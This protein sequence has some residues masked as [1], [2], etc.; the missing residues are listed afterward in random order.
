[1][2]SAHLQHFLTSAFSLLPIQSCSAFS[3]YFFLFLFFRIALMGCITPAFAVGLQ[4]AVAA[5]QA[6]LGE[7]A[8]GG[9]D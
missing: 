4:T 6:A 3:P 5:V 7:C 2:R 1:M 9:E 8:Q